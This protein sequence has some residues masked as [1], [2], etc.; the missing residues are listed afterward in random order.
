MARHPNK[1]PPKE[2]AGVVQDDDIQ[3]NPG[4]LN[5]QI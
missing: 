3:L 5:E 1:L 2:T 4:E